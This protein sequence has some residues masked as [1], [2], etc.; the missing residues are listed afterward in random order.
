M[1]RTIFHPDT[2]S[3]WAAAR[4]LALALALG[5]PLTDGAAAGEWKQ[6]FNVRTRLLS[7]TVAT[8]KDA[9]YVFLEIEMPKGWKTYW[10]NPGD[11]G[12]LPPRFDFKASENVAGAEVLYTAPSRLT[13]EAGETIGY[14]D[15]AVF[16]VRL[17]AVDPLK[18]LR[19]RLNVD[20]G[21]CKEICVPAQAEHEAEI[22]PAGDQPAPDVA[23]GALEAVPR[24]AGGAPRAEDPALVS[25]TLDTAGR[26]LVFEVRFPAGKTDGADVFV[27]GP[28]GIYIPMPQ[29]V[30]AATGEVQRF[31]AELGSLVEPKDLA[32][33][34]I[35]VTMVSAVGSAIAEIHLP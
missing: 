18:P 4:W 29:R 10:R 7:G 35:R 32:G 26:K 20:F 15:R 12:G 31:E 13:D 28:D 1:T 23:V 16:P 9:P 14:K 21:I 5:L 19:V 34:A 6:G 33:K 27:E 2:R 11:A 17:Q 3:T 22:A 25:G 30:G 24:T 8:E